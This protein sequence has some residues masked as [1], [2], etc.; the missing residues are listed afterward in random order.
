MNCDQ[1]EDKIV[2]KEIS[3]EEI[4]VQKGIQYPCM[5]L[6]YECCCLINDLLGYVTPITES[7]TPDLQNV[8][9]LSS[10]V[11]SPLLTSTLDSD[12]EVCLKE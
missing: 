11:W 8:K 6:E 7:I 10:K 5:L 12:K 2:E 9:H 3:G 1:P 4:P